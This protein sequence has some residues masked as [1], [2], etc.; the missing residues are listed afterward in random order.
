MLKKLSGKNQNERFS[1]RHFHFSGSH[2]ALLV[3]MPDS[4]SISHT[5]TI[6][7]LSGTSTTNA[8]CDPE[9]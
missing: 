7:V 1:E 3:L 8:K 6:G 5:I 2:F 9:K 4:T